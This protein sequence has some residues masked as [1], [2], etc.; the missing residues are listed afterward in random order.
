LVEAF[1]WF[2]K[3]SPVIIYYVSIQHWQNL[4]VL[5]AFQVHQLLQFIV[6]LAEHPNGKVR[7]SLPYMILG[8]CFSFILSHIL[9]SLNPGIA[10]EDGSRKDS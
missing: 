8:S 9:I 5:Y 2:L 10:L 7:G 6:K 1:F 3:F 4:K